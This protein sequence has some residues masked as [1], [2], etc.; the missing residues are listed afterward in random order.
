LSWS[1]LVFKNPSIPLQPLIEAL[2]S[3]RIQLRFILMIWNQIAKMQNGKSRFLSWQKLST[4]FHSRPFII[5]LASKWVIQKRLDTMAADKNWHQYKIG[6]PL[7]ILRLLNTKMRT[8]SSFITS[9]LEKPNMSEP[10][11]SFLSPPLSAL[12]PLELPSCI[13]LIFLYILSQQASGVD[14]LICNNKKKN[15]LQL[16]LFQQVLH[17]VAKQATAMMM[18]CQSYFDG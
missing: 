7:K 8:F 6:Q 15:Y 4:K 9:G 3:F 14:P 5:H 11:L 10:D 13:F 16:L 2:R 12:K 18:E 17:Y 1:E